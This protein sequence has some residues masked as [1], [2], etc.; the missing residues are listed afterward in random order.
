VTLLGLVNVKAQASQ[1]LTR[2]TLWDK[3]R[4]FFRTKVWKSKRLVRFRQNDDISGIFHGNTNILRGN[5]R[6]NKA[7][8]HYKLVQVT[9]GSVYYP[10]N[11][12]TMSHFLNFDPQMPLFWVTRVYTWVFI[13][14]AKESWFVLYKRTE[15]HLLFSHVMPS[16][17]YRFTIRLILL[18]SLPLCFF[19]F[20][21]CHLV[22]LHSLLLLLL[23]L[24]WRWY[25]VEITH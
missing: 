7:H 3:M 4:H 19:C 20:T 6:A 21:R 1:F 5:T 2:T 25:V 24:W 22:L 11:T 15:R 17:F 9:A 18:H 14:P 23:L 8:L 12:L 16:P 13:F 10:A